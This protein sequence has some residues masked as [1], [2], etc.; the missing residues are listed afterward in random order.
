MGQAFGWVLACVCL[1]LKISLPLSPQP[2]PSRSPNCRVLSG[3]TPWCVIWNLVH[4][5]VRTLH[6][7]CEWEAPQKNKNGMIIAPAPE[8]IMNASAPIN[9]SSASRPIISGHLQCL[10]CIQ[11]I[12]AS[13]L[14]DKSLPLNHHPLCRLLLCSLHGNSPGWAAPSSTLLHKIFNPLR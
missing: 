9:V 8:S 7:E 2:F 5:K 12:H 6:L 11:T 3:W 4:F 13:S 1:Q 10:L 14:R